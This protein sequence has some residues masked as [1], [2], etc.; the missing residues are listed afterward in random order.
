MKNNVLK[1]L[2]YSATLLGFAATI[3][4]NYV[5]EKEIDTKIIEEVAKVLIN[6]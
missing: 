3:L 6:K 5:S 2:G 1:L 4:S